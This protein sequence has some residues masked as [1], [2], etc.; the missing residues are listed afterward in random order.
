MYPYNITEVLLGDEIMYG[1]AN[2]S[3]YNLFGPKYPYI[4]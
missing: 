1:G 4:G 3:L 2:P